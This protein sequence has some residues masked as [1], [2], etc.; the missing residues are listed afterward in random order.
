[1]SGLVVIDNYDSFAYNLV[2]YLGELGA[3]VRVVRNDALDVDGLV[4]L[5]P[6]GIVISPGPGDPDDAGVALEAI[7]RLGKRIPVLG[8]CLGHQC[9]GAAYGGLVRRGAAPVHGKVS[10]IRHDG[11]TIFKGVA[12]PFEATRYH[13]L[14]VE[15]KSLPSALEVSAE[16]EDGTIMGVRHREYRVEGVQFHPESVLTACGKEILGNFLRLAG[17]GGGDE[18]RGSF[19]RFSEPPPNPV[20]R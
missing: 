2:Q 3:E 16:L 11:R 20:S 19:S 15:R 12:S 1:M 6:Q 10:R 14:I 9:I 13:S 8:V 5:E 7:R 17:L 18:N 4:A